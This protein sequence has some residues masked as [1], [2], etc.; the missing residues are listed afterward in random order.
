MGDAPGLGDVL[1]RRV[2]VEEDPGAQADLYHRLATLQIKEFG[3]KSQGLATLRLALEKKPEHDASR[4]S[5]EALL[6]DPLLFDEAFESLE[7]VYRQLGKTDDLSRL[8]ER[9]VGRAG[10][11]RERSRARLELA[12][13][14][15]EQVKDLPRA[16]RVVEEALAEDPS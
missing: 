16:Q 9:R 4:S 12:R 1:E 15:E 2:A 3:E 14:L 8:Y 6:E 5:L 10:S 11:A 7:G 13:V